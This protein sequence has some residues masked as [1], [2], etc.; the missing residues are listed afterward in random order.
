[1]P[2]C[3]QVIWAGGQGRLGRVRYSLGRLSTLLPTTP[4]PTL[5]P[6]YGAVSS[7]RPSVPSTAL[8]FLYD[9]VSSLKPYVP[10]TDLCPLHGPLP[11]PRLCFPSTACVPCTALCPLFSPLPSL[12]LFATAL[13][14]RRNALL[15]LA[16]CVFLTCRI[17]EGISSL[18][19][20]VILLSFIRWLANMACLDKYEQRWHR[21]CCCECVHPGLFPKVE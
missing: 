16:L 18:H 11:P 6:L 13:F 2:N 3:L 4:S 1:M 14:S 20:Y 5:C 7:L 15:P 9:P 12:E 8:C 10:S 19:T 21:R 17:R